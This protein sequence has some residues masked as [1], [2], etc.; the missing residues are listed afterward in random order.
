[1]KEPFSKR[2]YIG[3][4]D[5]WGYFIQWSF[6]FFRRKKSLFVENVMKSIHETRE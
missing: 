6:L 3:A 2:E 4:A 1:V 5:H